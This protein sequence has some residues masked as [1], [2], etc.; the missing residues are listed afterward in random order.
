MHAQSHVVIRLS[1]HLPDNRMVYFKENNVENAVDR[2]AQ[3]D[4]QLTA[5]FKL[6]QDN[7]LARQYLSP[8]KKKKIK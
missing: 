3:K 6:N 7:V 2:A 4:S 8:Q 5:W 1:V